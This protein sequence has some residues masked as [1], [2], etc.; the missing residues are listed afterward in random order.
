MVNAIFRESFMGSPVET[1]EVEEGNP[2]YRVENGALY[3]ENNLIMYEV[4]SRRS[5]FV[6]PEGTEFIW[7]G[8]F[9]GA[10]NL[11]KVTIA[12]TVKRIEQE[13]FL[14]M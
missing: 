8:A 3:A 7:D 10:S 5:E 9:Y 1:I 13:L 2:Y 6:V 4:G 14:W 12:S 11:K